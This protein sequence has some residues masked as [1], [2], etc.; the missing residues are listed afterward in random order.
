MGK[1]NVRDLV[2]GAAVCAVGLFFFAG[3][4]NMRVGSA[5]Q[6]GPG[7]FPMLVGGLVASI[8]IVI[9]LLAVARHGRFHEVHW[10]PMFAVLGAIAGFAAILGPFGL[11]PAMIVGVLLSTLGDRTARPVPSLVLAVGAGLGAWLVFRVG[12]G[13][14]MPGLKFPGWLG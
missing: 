7:Y 6:M 11:I 3:A 8:G 5:M 13:L 4:F 10:R 12:L 1:A 9:M 2:G 14:Q